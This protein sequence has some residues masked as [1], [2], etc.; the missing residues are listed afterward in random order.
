MLIDFNSVL[1]LTIPEMCN[2]TGE[3]TTQLYTDS[4]YTIE[5][6]RIHPGSSIGAH[7]MS[8]GDDL[9]YVIRGTGKVI[10]DGKEDT[11]RP[12]VMHIC[13]KGSAQT[14]INTGDEDLELLRI[15]VIR[16]QK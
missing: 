14:I 15:L 10:C 6:T 2:G 16:Q 9:Y 8:T 7:R 13:P 1:E 3:I 5:P 11:L 4:K 12:N